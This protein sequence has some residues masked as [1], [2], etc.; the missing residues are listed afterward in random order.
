[1]LLRL[2]T[3]GLLSLLV[4]GT[5]ARPAARLPVAVD[6]AIHD[7]TAA[8]LRAHIEVLASDDFAGRGL[9]HAGNRDAERYIVQALRAANVPAATPDYLQPI[10]VYEPHLGRDTRLTVTASDR[11]LVELALGA[12]LLPLPMS[13]DVTASGPLRFV[14]HGISAPRLHHDDYAAIDARGAVVLALEDAPDA[15]R[16]SPVLSSDERTEI[17]AV[18][19]KA[20]DARK[21]GAAGLIVIRSTVG[22]VRYT[23]PDRTSVRSAEYRLYAAMREH[24]LAVAVVSERAARPI[25]HALDTR[26]LLHVTLQPGIDAKPVVM[27]NVVAMVEG[28]RT[29]G[30][31]VVVGAHMDHDGIDEQGRIYNGADDNASGTAAVLAIASAFARAAA[32]GTR[33]ARAIVFAL[34]NGEEKGSLGAEY[35]VDHP[36]PSR[37]IVANVNLDMIGRDEDIPDPDD[38]R[39]RGFAKSSASQNTN[40]VHLLGYTYSPDLARLA[41]VA[42]DTLRLTIKQDYDRDSQSLVRRSDNWP[43]LQRSVPAVFLT[44]GLHPDY[45]TP[46]DDTVRLDFPKLERITELA[47]RL[48]WLAAEADAPRFAVHELPR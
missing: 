41:G 26:Q 48:A 17:A 31:V 23:W 20:D 15:L 11:P 4:G 47:A 21:H 6:E 30:E 32:Q 39:F 7:V 1:M 12:D 45:H 18:E 46:D 25:R 27:D 8:E 43:F 13:S 10:E 5:P 44:T 34:W 37:R 22:D 24:P 29:S 38:P 28:R 35:Y 42:N 19:R 40:V 36:V 9:G 14:G 2:V 3:V 33:P 16:H